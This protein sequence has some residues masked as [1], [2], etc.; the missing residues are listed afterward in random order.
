MLKRMINE[1][2][3]I[4]DDEVRKFYAGILAPGLK[5]KYGAFV[6]GELVAIAGILKDPVHFGTIFEESGKDIGFIDVRDGASRLG[7]R[8]VVEVKRFLEKISDA[9]FVQCDEK[10]YPNAPKL[11]SALGFTRTGEMLAD[12][13]SKAVTMEVWKWQP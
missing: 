10:N 9:I 3:E 2:R 11:L 8:A 4:S 13:R 7:F 5:H 6:D 1:Y 12:A